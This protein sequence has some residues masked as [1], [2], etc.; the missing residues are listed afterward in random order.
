MLE[1]LAASLGRNDEQPNVDLAIELC[2]SEDA[3]GIEQIVE[4][5]RD[6][7]AAVAGDCV[8][9]LYEIGSRKP[10]LIAPYAGEFITLL[11]SRNNRLVWGCMT[12]LAAV[13]ALAAET[14][15]PRLHEV[16]AAYETGSVITVDNAVS[17]FAGLCR[18]GEG[19]RAAAFPVLLRHLSTCRTKEVAQHVERAAMGISG[20]N[21]AAFVAAVQARLPELTPAQAARVNKAVRRLG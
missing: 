10:A 6:K 14:I 16:V 19:C 13:G 4:G 9:V 12:A 21:A 8:K 5:L 11:A 18:A 3:A 17:V 15:C 2:G 20:G 1:K 7:S